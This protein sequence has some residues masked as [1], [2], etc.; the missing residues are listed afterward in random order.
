MPTIVSLVYVS[1]M[2]SWAGAP[3]V[4][5]GRRDVSLITLYLDLAKNLNNSYDFAFGINSTNAC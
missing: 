4:T 1:A 2:I 5:K 3:W